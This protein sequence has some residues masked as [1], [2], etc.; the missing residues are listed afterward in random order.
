[1]TLTAVDDAAVVLRGTR[2]SKSD[3]V[4]RR[5][6]GTIRLSLV[7]RRLRN[8]QCPRACARSLLSRDIRQQGNTSTVVNLLTPTAFGY[9]YKASCARLG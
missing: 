6:V 7:G 5:Q 4:P 3:G 9:S 1:L 8:I 2:T